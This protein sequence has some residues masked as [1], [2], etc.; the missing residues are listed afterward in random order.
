MASNHTFSLLN[1]ND[2]CHVG[3]NFMYIPIVTDHQGLFH[4]YSG[5]L[6]SLPSHSWQ[7]NLVLV[8]YFLCDSQTV[9]PT[10]EANLHYARVT[11]G[12]LKWITKKPNVLHVKLRH[13]SSRFV[14]QS[15]SRATCVPELAFRPCHQREKCKNKRSSLESLIFIFALCF[16]RA[17]GPHFAMSGKTPRN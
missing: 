16:R 17:R 13:P 4:V 14:S 5:H 9:V 2:D 1:R 12:K 6:F 8:S 7:R 11:R 15:K 3:I 10:P